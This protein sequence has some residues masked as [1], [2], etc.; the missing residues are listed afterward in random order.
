MEFQCTQILLTG[1]GF[2]NR[3]VTEVGI[4]TRSVLVSRVLSTSQLPG[5]SLRLPP[6]FPAG[7]RSGVWQGSVPADPGTESCPGCCQG[8]GG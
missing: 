1:A 2:K 7:I 3:G 6:C 5:W 8:Q 4:K